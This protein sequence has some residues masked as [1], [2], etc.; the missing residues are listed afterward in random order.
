MC[1][2]VTIFFSFKFECVTDLELV[3]QFYK[4]IPTIFLYTFHDP[5]NHYEGTIGYNA[6]YMKA[7]LL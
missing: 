5:T 2:I 7:E 4:I 6:I 1:V 3:V